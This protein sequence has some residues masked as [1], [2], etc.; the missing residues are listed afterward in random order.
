MAITARRY[1]KSLLGEIDFQM[2]R[3][4]NQV[5]RRPLV[6]A[7]WLTSGAMPAKANTGSRVTEAFYSFAYEAKAII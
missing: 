3:T 4:E 1:L 2:Q 7:F 5:N 6:G